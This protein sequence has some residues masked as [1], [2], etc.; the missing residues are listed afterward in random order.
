MS[1]NQY[2]WIEI[3]RAA[4]LEVDPAKLPALIAE[5]ENVIQQRLRDFHGEG[6]AAAAERQALSDALQN[7][8]VIR[9]EQPKMS[10]APLHP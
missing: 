5:A 7:L 2:P 1:G 3:Y 10:T 8:R 6:P 9:R 4:L